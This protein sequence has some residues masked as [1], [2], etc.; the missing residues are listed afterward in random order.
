MTQL[1]TRPIIQKGVKRKRVVVDTRDFMLPKD[2]HYR[3][4]RLL[5]TA[6]KQ[7]CTLMFLHSGGHNPAT[8]VACHSNQSQ[9]GKGK[10]IK[11]HDCYIAYGCDNCHTILDSNSVM[12]RLYRNE[13]FADAMAMT[14][15]SMFDRGI[16]RP[17]QEIDV[18]RTFRDD[19]YWLELWRDE[20]LRV[21]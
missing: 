21:A 13:K 20:K 7:D 15:F 11:A 19:A 4:L 16:I 3:N 17:V 8:T 6:N 12:S 14:R 2:G 5:A 9:H 18:K 10:S 1:A